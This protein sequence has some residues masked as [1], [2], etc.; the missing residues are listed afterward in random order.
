MA[1]RTRAVGTMSSGSHSVTMLCGGEGSKCRDGLACGSPARTTF[2]PPP[3][4]LGANVNNAASVAN[5]FGEGVGGSF[6]NRVRGSL[7]IVKL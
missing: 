1:A 6:R 3:L 4:V 5:F 2:Y 7:P